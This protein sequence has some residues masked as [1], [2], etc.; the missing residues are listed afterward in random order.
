MA[1]INQPDRPAGLAGEQR[2]MD[3]DDGGVL[4]FP[5]E[6]AARLG[7]D[8]DRL[9]IAKLERPLERA[10]DVVGALQ[11]SDDSDDAARF[12]YGD[13]CLRLDVQL[14]LQPDT[15]AALHHNLNTLHILGSL[16]LADVDRA[17]DLGGL[18]DREDGFGRVIVD[19][20]VTGRLLE[21]GTVGG[22][23]EQ[24]WLLAVP[25]LSADGGQ[26]GLVVPNEMD[27]VLAW[28]VLSRY[29]H[30]PAPV[31]TRIAPYGLETAPGDAGSDGFAVP[32]ARDR[33]VIGI[34]GDPGHLGGALAARNGLADGGSPYHSG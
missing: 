31:K 30:H 1:V 18:V 26:D 2:R 20:D 10:M 24:N 3:R 21:G 13:G 8:H 15:E 17:E 32:G 4:L 5:A 12:G 14:L 7:L 19:L 34:A 23:Q 28:D 16:A 25:D 6:P 11:R 27:D 33:Q 9:L 29:H 22:R